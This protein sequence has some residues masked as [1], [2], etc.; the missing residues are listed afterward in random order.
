MTGLDRMTEAIRAEGSAEAASIR[1][2]AE[3]EAAR[4]RAEGEAAAAAVRENAAREADRLRAR[5][6]AQASSQA[7]LNARRDTLQAK[8]SMIADVLE[9]AVR[10]I[11]QYD[12]SAYFSALAA[13][14]APYAALGEGE[15]L[16]NERDAARVPADFLSNVGGNLRLSEETASIR[17]GCI[18]RFGGIEE[19]CSLEALLR[20]KREALQDEVASILFA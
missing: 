18:L 7:S 5:I 19:N 9:E 20:N 3:K 17:G 12:T 11:E 1:A 14:I 15:I 2:E 16:F 10:T 8:Q 4:I 13:L 6:L